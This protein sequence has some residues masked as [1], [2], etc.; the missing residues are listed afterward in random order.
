MQIGK[1]IRVADFHY[2]CKL[3][4]TLF[5]VDNM[6]RGVEVIGKVRGVTTCALCAVGPIGREKN[7][8]DVG[9]GEKG[10]L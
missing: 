8:I 1:E 5:Y 4:V 3:H 7:A 2:V 10:D 9:H 6:E